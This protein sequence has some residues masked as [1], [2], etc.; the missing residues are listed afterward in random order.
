MNDIISYSIPKQYIEILDQVF[1]I[2]KK[3]ESI[4]E[5]NS[6]GRNIN[7]IKEMFE[8]L[9]ED[10]GLFYQNPLGEHFN[11]TRTDLEAS[12]AGNST[13]N[14]MVTEVIKPIIRFR[15]NSGATTIVRK[16]V[17]VVESKI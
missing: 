8:Y 5:P 9:T 10:S 1:E 14:L 16:G 11:E 12:I 17:V 4:S 6:V 2:E 13:D 3:L 7:R 15:T